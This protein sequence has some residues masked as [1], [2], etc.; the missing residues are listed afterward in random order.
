MHDMVFEGVASVR[1]LTLARQ[2]NQSANVPCARLRPQ[3]RH[4][5]E[6][7]EYVVEDPGQHGFAGI[8]TT[9]PAE[10]ST[11]AMDVSTVLWRLRWL[12]PKRQ[13]LL[14]Q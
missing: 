6:N 5:H 3:E 11:P 2:T 9:V 10:A 4:D 1:H 8:A 12:L 7:V 14:H 13:W